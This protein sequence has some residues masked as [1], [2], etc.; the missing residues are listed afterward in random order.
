[1]QKR[2]DS[3]TGISNLSGGVNINDFSIIG[4]DIWKSFKVPTERLL[5]LHE[6]LWNLIRRKNI[7]TNYLSVLK[8]VNFKVRKGE[9]L[10]IIGDNGSGKST[11][12]KILAKI[13]YPD[14]GNVHVKGKVASFIELGVG[15]DPDLTAED[16]VYLYGSVLG[17]SRTKIKHNLM[18]IYDFAELEKFRHMRLRNFSSGMILRLAFSTAMQVEPEVLLLDEVLAVGDQDFQKKCMNKIYEFV[19]NKKTIVFVSHDLRTVQ[20]ICENALWLNKG[21]IA[22]YGKSE[23][24]IQDYMDYVNKNAK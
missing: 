24:V 9:T 5:R 8:G 19:Q 6:K 21:I 1:L 20:K 15:F 23:K 12:L 18:Q 7:D 14:K 11:L 3:S 13:I 22:S 16:N 2:Y 17:L 4:E 10:G